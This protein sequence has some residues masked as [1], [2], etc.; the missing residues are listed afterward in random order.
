M[1][2]YLLIKPCKYRNFL[3]NQ[4]YTETFRQFVISHKGIVPI[5]SVDNSSFND[6][7]HLFSFDSGD[8]FDTI[9]QYVRINDHVI[10]SEEQYNNY[11]NSILK[12][13]QY[14]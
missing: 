1:S 8:I 6:N 13:K 3:S 5:K 4:Y 9:Y 2:Q 14:E 12:E 7:D 10:L 11:I